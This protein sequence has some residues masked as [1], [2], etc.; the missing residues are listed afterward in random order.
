MS[1][2]LQ[3]TPQN[4]TLRW[5]S[6]KDNKSLGRTN[7]QLEFDYDATLMTC[8]DSSSLKMFPKNSSWSLASPWDVSPAPDV[9]H[10]SSICLLHHHPRDSQQ[11]HNFRYHRSQNDLIT[12][13]LRN[14][15]N[16]INFNS[17]LPRVFVLIFAVRFVAENR[18]QQKKSSQSTFQNYILI[19]KR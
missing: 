10:K 13:R 3:T 12:S 5:R 6:L 15:I 9:T 14:P 4:S 17:S 1:Q 19:F 16:L 11:S 7:W 8:D 2:P 18:Q